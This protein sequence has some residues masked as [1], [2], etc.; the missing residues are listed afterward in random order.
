MS[1]KRVFSEQE[2]TEIMQRA[3][4]LQ[5]SSKTGDS[6]LPGVTIDELKRIAEEAGIDLK[7]IYSAV[8]GIDTEEKSTKGV[9]N[10]TE[11]FERVVDGEMDPEDFDKILHLVRRSG[12][13]GLMQVGRTVTGQ[14]TVGV[15]VVQI[16][17]E[18]RHGRT[19]AKVKYIPLSAYF[20]G[21][22]MPIILSIVALASQ[23]EAG[24][25]G[26][27]VIG[28]AAM[29]GVGTA[30]FQWLVKA[31]RR[32]AKK[33]T[34]DIVKVIEQEIDPLRQ[35]LELSTSSATEEADVKETT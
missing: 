4:R 17:V 26:F 10:L 16:E 22:H 1:K 34:G 33:L 12:K 7:H 24:R 19:R 25:P 32:A 21:L 29:L 2:A 14:G 6:Y 18:S 3:V 28:A 20:I 30:V 5:E 31:G 15:H 11:E 9:F 8:A 23:F 13:G 27:G 35:N